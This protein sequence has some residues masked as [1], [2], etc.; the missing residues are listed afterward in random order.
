MEFSK[1]K[2]VKQLERLLHQ[3]VRNVVF[4]GRDLSGMK[5]LDHL[6]PVPRIIIP[7]SGC[8]E[9]T[10]PDDAGNE[11]FISMTPGT[12]LFCD[13]CCWT[14]PSWLRKH[15]MISIVYHENYIRVLYLECPGG[16]V[17]WN[18]P[19]ER[20]G[21]LAKYYFHTPQP[22]S[23]VGKLLLR[24]ISGLTDTP[25]LRKAAPLMAQSLLRLTL[26]EL[27]ISETVKYSKSFL[28]WQKIAHY[29]QDNLELDSL[30]RQTVADHFILS[31]NHL[32]R[33]CK[34][35][36]DC[37]FHT[38]LNELRLQQAERMLQKTNMTV[39]EIADKCGYRYTSYFIRIFKKM[40]ACS[41]TSYRQSV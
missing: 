37:S 2:T 9:I 29:L 25:I 19:G 30:S 41:P 36:A 10:I 28:T 14:R 11:R 15:E 7:L 8:K 33:L 18:V 3:E 5:E 35:Y 22:M 20:N 6:L 1:E 17:E 32:S 23:H 27:R 38:Y 39:D 24:S 4:T 16:T 31:P 13:E 40:H 34:Q 26:E 12:M 21:P